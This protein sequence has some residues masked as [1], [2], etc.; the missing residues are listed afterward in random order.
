MSNDQ[1]RLF[2]HNFA[3]FS[4]FFWKPVFL[5]KIYQK[6]LLAQILFF[7][8]ILFTLLTFP[9]YISN[10]SIQEIYRPGTLHIPCVKSAYC[11]GRRSKQRI[12]RQRIQFILFWSTPKTY[13][14]IKQYI[15]VCICVMC[16]HNLFSLSV[17]HRYRYSI[18]LLLDWGLIL[19]KGGG[20]YDKKF[21]RRHVKE[22]WEGEIYKM[23]S[24]VNV[25]K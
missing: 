23:R 16:K 6:K 22:K 25:C 5:K 19:L 21:I 10:L 8:K 11:S 2:V 20:R 17:I 13:L 7:F 3:Y 24:C 15:N 14:S 12:Q 1:C 4:L 18:L 9:T